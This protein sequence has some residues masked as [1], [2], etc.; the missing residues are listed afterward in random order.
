MI[1]IIRRGVLEKHGESRVADR[2][3]RCPSVAFEE[4][5]EALAKEH[6]EAQVAL[7]ELSY[8]CIVT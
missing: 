2:E 3:W 4:H 7:R 6:N 1:E 8:L 5:N